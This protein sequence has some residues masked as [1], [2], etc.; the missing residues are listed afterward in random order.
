MS[1]ETGVQF[2]PKSSLSNTTNNEI[3]NCWNT[4]IKKKLMRKRIHSTTHKPK[5]NRLY[6]HQSKDVITMKHL[7]QQESARFAAKP[8]EVEFSS[9]IPPVH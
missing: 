4:N 7:V 8:M 1:M 9:F 6:V 5:A 3:K 2:Q